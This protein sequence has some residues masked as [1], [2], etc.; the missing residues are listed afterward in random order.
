MM[1]HLFAEFLRVV[2]KLEKGAWVGM[3]RPPVHLL[4]S[5]A[6]P[7]ADLVEPIHNV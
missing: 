7:P 5:V 1:R 2:H 3:M 4:E 6:R